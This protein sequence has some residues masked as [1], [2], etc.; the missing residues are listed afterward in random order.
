MRLYTLDH[1]KEI[2]AALKD[3][4]KTFLSFSEKHTETVFPGYTH[5][6]QAMPSSV[7]HWGLSF[8]ESLL[9]DLETVRFVGHAISKNPLGTAAGFGVSFPLDRELTRKELGFETN[10][11]N[12]IFAQ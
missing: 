8:V 1:L 7:A 12:S 6:Q 11:V 3:L 5:T 9:S 10:I 2:E 4:A